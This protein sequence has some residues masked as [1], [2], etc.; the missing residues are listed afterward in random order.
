MPTN[1]GLSVMISGTA[2]TPK[3]LASS[4]DIVLMASAY[5]ET[6]MA[7]FIINIELENHLSACILNLNLV[8]HLR[9]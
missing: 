2:M 4:L 8:K 1:G 9:W 5:M 3:W 7:Y 6:W